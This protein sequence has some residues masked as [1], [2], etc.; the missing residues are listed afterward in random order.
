MNIVILT[1]LSYQTVL[2]YVDAGIIPYQLVNRHCFFT[3]DSLVLGLTL[4]A[5]SSITD[6]Y[7]DFYFRGLDLPEAEEHFSFEHGNAISFQ[8]LCDKIISEYEINFRVNTLKAFLKVRNIANYSVI[9]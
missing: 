6:N 8:E 9:L 2:N 1:G 5:K 4:N 7:L 3:I